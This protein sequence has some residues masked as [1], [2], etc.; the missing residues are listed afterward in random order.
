MNNQYIKMKTKKNY[1]Y[2]LDE[3][4]EKINKALQG[5]YLPEKEAWKKIMAVRAQKE[6]ERAERD[7]KII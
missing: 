4:E 7:K 5:G 3:L 2:T 1:N 6:K